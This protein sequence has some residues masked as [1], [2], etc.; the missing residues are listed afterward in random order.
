[1]ANS[2]AREERI[3]E[4]GRQLIQ[5]ARAED[6]RLRK[7]HRLEMGLL[8]W[9]MENPDLKK[10]I[11]QFIDVFPDLHS[12]RS[13]LKHAKE[14]F[15]H[16]E[17]RL[18]KSLR[19]GMA[20]T[21]PELFSR[22]IFNQVTQWIYSRMAHLF[23]GATTESEVL[24]RIDELNR[25]NITLSIDLL[26]ESTLSEEEAGEYY[27]RY[28]K[29]IVMLG[30]KGLGIEKQNISIKLS[31]LDPFFDPI[32]REGVNRRARHQLRNLLR[33]ARQNN[34]FLHIDMEEYLYRDL[35][36]DIVNSLLEESEFQNGAHLGIVI[37]AYLKD[38]EASLS[39][40]LPWA[41]K[42]P[43]PLT[44][45][46]VRGA[47]WDTEVIKAQ[48]NHWQIPVFTKKSD[49]DQTFERLTEKILDSTPKVHLAVATH[50]IRSIAH[51]LSLIEEKKIPAHSYEFQLLYGMG[52]SLMKALCEIGHPPRMYMPIGE[53]VKGMAYLV[54][55]LLENVSSESFVRKGIHT[56]CDPMS[57]EREEHFWPEN[58]KAESNT[59][60]IA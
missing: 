33:L 50:N 31:A 40:I 8:D 34:V 42:L 13:V 16:Q 59:A 27:G 17:H 22:R 53:P 7:Q 18:P 51:A 23:I 28:E 15:P 49:T 55:R 6:A 52:S 45:R 57:R 5:S 9:C 58:P 20:I 46:L 11:F 29:L 14:Y 30:Q 48:E 41:E 1:M 19:A 3:Q 38:A 43:I 10:R 39:R 47:Y 60:G 56:E 25:E 24:Q 4:L 54:R 21:G 32:D 37:Q 2:R 35:T 12:P 36:V 44:I 26:G